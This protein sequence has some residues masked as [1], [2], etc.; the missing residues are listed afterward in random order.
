MQGASLPNKVAAFRLNPEWALGNLCSRVLG[1]E[2]LNLEWELRVS[3]QGARPRGSSANPPPPSSPHDWQ[4]KDGDHVQYSF[5]SI[6]RYTSV[7]FLAFSQLNSEPLVLKQSEKSLLW[8][9]SSGSKHL[10]AEPAASVLGRVQVPLR[11]R[12]T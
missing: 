8:P 2:L 10:P 12:V 5:K 9:S 3:S 1:R 7:L 11:G 6:S 4:F